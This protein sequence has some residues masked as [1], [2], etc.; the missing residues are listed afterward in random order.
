MIFVSFLFHYEKNGAVNGLCM[1]MNV[2]GL[3]G[4]KEVNIRNMK[5]Y[6][7]MLIF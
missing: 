4:R 5:Y 7:W 2:N 1:N 6:R 3:A